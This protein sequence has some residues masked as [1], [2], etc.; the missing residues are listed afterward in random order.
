M[1]L[2]DVSPIV[3]RTRDTGILA[4]NGVQSFRLHQLLT[5]FFPV[6]CFAIVWFSALLIFLTGKLLQQAVVGLKGGFVH[7]V[8]WRTESP[9]VILDWLRK[10]MFVGLLWN[11]CW[12]EH[13]NLQLC[14]IGGV[15]RLG[16]WPRHG[17]AGILLMWMAIRPCGEEG[18]WLEGCLVFEPRV[19]WFAQPWRPWWLTLG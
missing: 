19:V 18:I 12:V 1:P 8:N 15:C 17:K 14:R 2:V 4:V 9:N 3:A 11:W 10:S 16:W 6:S 7:V 13:R 5:G